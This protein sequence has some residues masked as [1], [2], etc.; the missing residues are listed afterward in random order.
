MIGRSGAEAQM[1]RLA[2]AAVRVGPVLILVIL[3]AAMTAAEPIFFTERNIQ[4]VLVQSAVVATIGL[5][6]LVAIV[7]R[8][9]DLSVGAI[10]AL[11]TVVGGLVYNSAVGSGATV[12]LAIVLTGGIVGAVN[13]LIYV[14]GRIPHP[15]IVTLAMLSVASGLALVLSGG[16]SRA[17][18]PDIVQMLGS[19]FVG[20]VPVPALVVG[21]LAA[22]T[23]VLLSRVVWGTWV[24]AIGGNPDAA[25]EIGLPVDRILVSVYIFSGLMAG[26]GG[27]ITAGR[28]NAA[29]P[30]AGTGAELDSI[31]AVIIGG[32]S[33]FGGRGTVGSVLVGALTIGVVRNGLNLLNVSPSWQL[34]AIGAIIV[35]AVQLD[36]VRTRLEANFRAAQSPDVGS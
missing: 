15:F 24:Y 30:T 34:V 3:V 33:F 20:P 23:A 8:G 1:L 27:V 14:K 31:A 28:T 19:D 16:Q 10:V 11:S 26:V 2:L 36:V 25:R 5:G 22:F 18:M 12:L 7:T 21:L 6:Q 9:I 32:A 13:G 4:N 35:V 29:F 17:G